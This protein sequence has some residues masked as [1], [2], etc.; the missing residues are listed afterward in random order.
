MSLYIRLYNITAQNDYI[1]SYKSGNT[2]GDATTGFT[3]YNRYSKN[4]TTL[5]ITG[6]TLTTSTKYWVKLQDVVTNRYIIE[7]I[8]AHDDCFYNCIDVSPTPTKTNT[9]TPTKTPTINSATICIGDGATEACTCSST[10]TVYYTGTFGAGTTLYTSSSLST[11]YNNGVRPTINY[12]NNIYTYPSGGGPLTLNGVCISTTQTNTPTPTSTINLTQTQTPTQ[13]PTPI[14]CNPVV[15]LSYSSGTVLGEGYIQIMIVLQNNV[16]TDTQITVSV[17]G[18]NIPSGRNV[19]VFIPSGNNTAT[20]VDSIGAPYDP[21]VTS[22]CISIVN[23]DNTI[24]CTNYSCE[25]YSCPC[26]I[27]STPLPTP[28]STPPPTPPAYLGQCVT[29]TNADLENAIDVSYLSTQGIIRCATISLGETINLCIK[30][31][32]IS[33][34]SASDSYDGSCS[35]TTPK[36]ITVINLNKGCNSNGDCP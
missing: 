4:T 2:L 10:A 23:G 31:E 19:S 29:I 30:N 17:I 5:T 33:T 36:A 1:V 35:G 20:I 6:T 12:N 15:N 7:N 32:G 25:S 11:K 26:G 21:L 34:I 22:A 13:T 18:E 8:K 3:T 27:P 28:P 9:P 24:S 14:T 16:T